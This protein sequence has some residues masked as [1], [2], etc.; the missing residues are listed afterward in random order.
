[1]ISRSVAFALEATDGHLLTGDPEAIFRGARIDSRRIEGGEIFFALPGSQADGHEYA[2]RASEAGA[3]VVVVH[4]DL[5]PTGGAAWLRVE[6]TYAAFHDLTRA[7]RA[8]VPKKLVGITGSAGKTTTKELLAVLLARKFQVSRT[9]GNL[10]NL[11]GFPLA[12]LSID[13]PCDWM[14]AE[15]GMSTPEELAGV[16]RLGRP[17]AAVF[18]NVRP[19][20]LMNFPNLRG[21]TEAKA[22]LLAGLAAGGLVV[23]NADDPEVC[24]IAEHYTESAGRVLFY[25]FERPAEVQGLALRPL[26]GAV[27]NRFTLRVDGA[28]QD[29]VLPIHGLYNAENCL[30]A[31][32]C[33]WALGVSLEEMAAALAEFQTLGAMRSE[34]IHLPDGSAVVNDSYNSNPDAAQKALQGAA[35]LP[36]EH[37][38][39]VLGDMLELGSEEAAFHVSVGTKAAELGFSVLGVGPLSRHLV[40]AVQD[41]GAEAWHVDDAAAAV[42]WMDAA[43]RQG[44]VPAGSTILV[45]GSRAIGLEVVAEA[46]RN[47]EKGT[48]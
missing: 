1:M 48:I 10:N 18:T 47:E 33:A 16:S 21:I 4:Q 38:W 35:V 44:T 46:L 37:R 22:G 39:A 36:G 31:C 24:H 29:I 13:E 34:V 40:E 17:D 42:E 27:G 26:E 6:D 14:V 23:V 41:G 11:Y 43:R 32:A 7:V 15:M 45:K 30:A 12:L 9:P 2:A 20:H 28:E 3:A 8:E 5:E 19:A 25:G